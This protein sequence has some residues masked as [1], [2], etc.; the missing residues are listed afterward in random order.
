MFNI[1]RVVPEKGH[2]VEEGKRIFKE[3]YSL[4]L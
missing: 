4:S 3:N 2:L 1:N